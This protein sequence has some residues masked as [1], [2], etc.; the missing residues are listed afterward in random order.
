MSN[1]RSAM[2]GD[3]WLV[4]RNARK[5]D[6]DEL[7]ALG[8]TAEECIRQGIAH[9]DAL[10]FEING[11]PAG[12][13]G[14][15][16]NDDHRIPWAVFTDAIESHSV[17]FLRA[18]RRWMDREKQQSDLP[19][20]NYVDVRNTKII[21]WLKWLGFTIGEAEAIGV[22]GEQFYKFTLCATPG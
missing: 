9:S 10:T 6:R 2:P 21:A 14:V 5:D 22:N 12:V 3:T 20:L 19:M 8:V 1:F 7:A 13:I 4:A 11:E 16:E 17:T 18:S 15:I